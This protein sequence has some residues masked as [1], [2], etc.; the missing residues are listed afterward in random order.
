MKSKRVSQNKNLPCDMAPQHFPARHPLAARLV[1]FDLRASWRDLSQG[2]INPRCELGLGLKHR[3]E[4]REDLLVRHCRER[5]T[6][7]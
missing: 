4:A 3:V 6:E 7:P 5:P 1:V 2:P